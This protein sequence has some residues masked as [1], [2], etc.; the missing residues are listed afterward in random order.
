MIEKKTKENDHET[1]L[2]AEEISFWAFTGRWAVILIIVGL[3][4]LF[5]EEI[6]GGIIVITVALGYIIFRVQKIKRKAKKINMKYPAWWRGSKMFFKIIMIIILMIILNLFIRL[7]FNYVGIWAVLILA[8]I[9]FGYWFL[10]KKTNFSNKDK[11]LFSILPAITIGV[12][13]LIIFLF[14]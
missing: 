11:I 1:S 5:T 4:L 14:S 7:I 12:L 8:A 2:L 10:W 3:V 6:Y 9:L 13:Y